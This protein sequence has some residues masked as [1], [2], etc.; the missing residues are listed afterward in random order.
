MIQAKC[1]VIGGGT[2]SFSVLSGLKHQ[3]S[4]IAALVS[5]ADDGGSTG[6]LRDDMG[7][8]PPGDVRKCLVALSDAPQELRELFNYRYENGG[9]QGHSF[10]NLFLSTVEKMTNNFADAVRIAGDV[11]RINGRVIPITLTDVR[12]AIAWSDGTVVRGE[13]RIDVMKFVKDRGLPQLYLEPEAALNPEAQEAIMQADIIVIAPGDLY[14]SLGPLLVVPGVA[15]ALAK[16]KAKKVYV[17]NLVSKPGQT[18]GLTVAGHAAEIER[19]A[20]G[21]IIDHVLYNTAAPPDYLVEKYMSQGELPIEAV[22]A[23]FRGKH[24]R[25]IGVSLIADNAAP[26]QKSDP[27]AAHRTFIRHDGEALARAV[28]ELIPS[29]A[30]KPKLQRPSSAA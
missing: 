20:G 18:D 30:A 22:A 14:T 26:V 19:F 23:E 7:V 15:E 21:K 12:L 16:T 25:A 24:Y 13:G 5:M 2:G 17:C 6:M 11:L 8:L 3:I 27:L 1:V 4:D 28:L 29:G 10:G 9:L